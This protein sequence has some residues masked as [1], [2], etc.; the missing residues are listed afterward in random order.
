MN[1]F[2]QKCLIIAYF[3]CDGDNEHLQ[4]CISTPNGY[5]WSSV[6]ISQNVWNVSSHTVCTEDGDIHDYCC[7]NLRSYIRG[8]RF[9]WEVI[10][11]HLV[12]K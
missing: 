10:V 3:L 6:K 1:L 8:T 7:E 11:I 12:K 2:D 4:C 9:A 5:G